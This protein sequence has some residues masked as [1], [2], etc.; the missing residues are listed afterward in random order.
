MGD[1]YKVY[2]HICPNG[3]RYYGS[4]KGTVKKRWNNGKGYKYN[5]NF[6]EDI[7]KYGWNDIQHIIVAKGLSKDEAIW[8][9]EELTREWKTSNPDKSYNINYGDRHSEESKKK[10]GKGNKGKYVSKDT[11]KKMSEV[12]VGK[13]NPRSKSVICLT[14]RRV[15]YTAKEGA[16]YY[17]LKSSS[18]ITKCCQ[19]KHKS[20]GKLNGQKLV[21][22]Y[23][24]IITL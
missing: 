11:K 8:L 17:G 9:E 6:W 5:D 7:V 14:T 21:W 22:K 15:F 13:S 18:D 24:T 3:K 4:T 20:A 10:I 23:I 2:V 19:G 1:E 12:K 16:K